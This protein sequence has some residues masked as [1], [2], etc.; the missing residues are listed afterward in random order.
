MK[1][2]IAALVLGAAVAAGS[3]EAAGC[4]RPVG[5]AAEGE[6]LAAAINRFRSDQ[7]LRP[8]AIAPQLTRA[9]GD[10]ACAMV[11]RNEFSHTLGGSAKARIHKAGCSAR[12]VGENIAMGYGQ[13]AQVFRQWLESPG[14][15]KVMALKGVAVMGIGVAAPGPGQGGG[16]RWVLQVAAPCR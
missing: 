9:A 11:A 16:P 4:G 2:L 15:R 14:H 12:L 10:H 8:L 13:G 6:A 1:S 5:E 3:A 7:G